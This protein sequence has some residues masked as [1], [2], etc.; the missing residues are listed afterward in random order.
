MTLAFGV[1]N[2]TIFADL[3]MRSISIYQKH[4]SPRK[5]YKCAYSI[6]HNDLSCS[7]YCKME[8]STNGL[9]QGIKNTLKRFEDCKHSAL[10]I[11]EK[12]IIMKE[13]ARGSFSVIEDQCKRMD[14]CDQIMFAELLGEAACCACSS[15]S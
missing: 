10:Q 5:G 13:K 3:A 1:F 2:M 4:I 15:F 6:L 8:I 11:K 14:A 9:M 7:D 12:R